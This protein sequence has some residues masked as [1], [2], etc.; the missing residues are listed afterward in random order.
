MR[1]TS[2]TF[3][4]SMMIG[5][6]SLAARSRRQIDRPSSPGSIRSS[7]IRSIGLA[8]QHPVQRLCVLGQQHVEAFLG[9]VAAQQVA[10]AGVVVDDDDAVGAAL[11]GAVHRCD[12]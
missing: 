4:V 6:G 9:Q 11:A 10:D 1:S 5:V 8:R 2:S 3:A 7:T 12:S